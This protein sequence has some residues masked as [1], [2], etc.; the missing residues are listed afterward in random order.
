[1]LMQ[2]LARYDH[3]TR[4]AHLERATSSPEA[5]REYSNRAARF[6]QSQPPTSIN[7]P[8]VA[9]PNNQYTGRPRQAQLST[10]NQ[11]PQ[12]RQSPAARAQPQTLPSVLQSPHRRAA[13]E[14]LAKA[15]P[16]SSTRQSLWRQADNDP[17]AMENLRRLLARLPL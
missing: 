9:S 5:L 6:Q 15:Y 17:A 13:D 12:S 14:I 10:T 2:L 7:R 4:K 11:I 16:D 8:S 1:M 3:A